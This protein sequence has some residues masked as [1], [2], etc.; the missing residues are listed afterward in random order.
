MNF[1]KASSKQLRSFGLLVGTV[2]VLIGVWPMLFRAAS[3]RSWALILAGLLLLPA[4]FVPVVLQPVYRAWMLLGSILGWIN[5][6]I[7]LGVIFYMVFTPV[8][9]LMRLFGRD[10]LSLRS[11][12]SDSYRVPREPRPG[13]HMRNQF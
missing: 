2:L 10:P 6:R 9:L 5:T 8:G 7:I 1:E 11:S 13:T 12:A 4:V 3:P